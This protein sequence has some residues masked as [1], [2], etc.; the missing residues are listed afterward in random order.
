VHALGDGQGM[1]VIS[2][3]IQP[4]TTPS[5]VAIMRET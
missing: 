3:R 5:I 4:A 2:G 1:N